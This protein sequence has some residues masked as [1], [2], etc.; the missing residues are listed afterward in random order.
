MSV[1]MNPGATALTVMLRLPISCASDFVSP[2]KPGFR[3][4]IIR[5]ARDFPPRRP[6]TKY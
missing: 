3:G 4:D 1:S 5:L 6:P 2:I